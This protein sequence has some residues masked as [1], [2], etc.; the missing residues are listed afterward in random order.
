MRDLWQQKRRFSGLSIMPDLCVPGVAHCC[1]RSGKKRKRDLKMMIAF[2][3]KTRRKIYSRSLVSFHSI[4]TFLQ[5]D[6]KFI[7]RGPQSVA[8]YITWSN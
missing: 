4:I 7:S 3:V 6:L 8:D 1:V 2:S 5:E